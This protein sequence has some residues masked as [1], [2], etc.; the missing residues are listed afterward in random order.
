MSIFEV[1]DKLIKAI[2]SEQYDLIV[3]N[4]ANPDMLGHTG[5]FDAVVK[6]LEC[7]DENLG[8]IINSLEKIN[9]EMVIIADHG[10]AEKMYNEDTGQ[11]HTA[12]TCAPVPFIYMGNK[13]KVTNKNGA[14]TDVAPTILYL[15]GVEIPSEMTGKTLLEKA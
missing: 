9:G 14:L 3:C 8:K 4:F 12:H 5:E 15:L 6:A 1:T 2:E 7:V 13:S 10:N 11:A